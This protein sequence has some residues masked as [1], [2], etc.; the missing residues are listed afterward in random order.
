MIRI[1]MIILVFTL[2]EFDHAAI[3]PK[4]FTS[5]SSCPDGSFQG[6]NRQDC[7]LYNDF[8]LTWYWALINCSNTGGE[9]ASIHDAFT[10]DLIKQHLSNFTNQQTWIG[11][12]LTSHCSF[13]GFC[14]YSW[15]WVDNSPFNYYN[16]AGEYPDPTIYE[17]IVFNNNDGLWYVSHGL[18]P[19]LCKVPPKIFF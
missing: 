2:I 5:S 13:D 7:F 17:N 1:L 19:F 10:N 14:S 4:N 9:L 18:H 16:F 6:T 12:E 8:P 15:G 3:L 11:G